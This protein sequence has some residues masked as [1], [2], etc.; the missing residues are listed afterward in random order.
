[1]HLGCLPLA[2]LVLGI[3]LVNNVDAALSPDDFVVS[4]PLLNTC[5]NF[6]LSKML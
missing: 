2:L 1:M 4:A 6:H 5:A 3:L